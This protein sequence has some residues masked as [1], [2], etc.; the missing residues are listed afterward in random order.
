MLHQTILT[1]TPYLTP[2]HLW[3]FVQTA[4]TDMARAVSEL[5]GLIRVQVGKPDRD[6]KP[7]PCI[8]TPYLTHEEAAAY[9][10]VSRWTLYHHRKHIPTQ[11]GIGRN[12]Y[13]REDLDA[14]MATRPKRK[15]R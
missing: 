2:D 8:D 4:R 13:R 1:A 11:P 15:P 14:W 12:V 6:P 10:R 3:Q 5:E 9:C 7:V